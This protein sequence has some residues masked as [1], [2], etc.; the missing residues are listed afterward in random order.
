MMAS[1]AD[2]DAP[3]IMALEETAPEIV[4]W[5]RML[6]LLPK[7]RRPSDSERSLTSP[8]S[9][10]PSISLANATPHVRRVRTVD[11][12]LRRV[13]R[14]AIPVRYDDGKRVFSRE[15]ADGIID[16]N[17]D[18]NEGRDQCESDGVS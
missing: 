8:C 18:D 13:V 16:L 7:R 11:R 9:S 1:A 12:R 14:S 4:K 15:N 17:E 6:G 10:G 5:R 3:V 2:G